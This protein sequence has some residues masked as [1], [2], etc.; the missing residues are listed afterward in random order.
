METILPIEIGVS[1][2]ERLQ[3]PPPVTT[4]L[5]PP[6]INSIQVP[7][8]D[9]PFAR[10]DYPTLEIPRQENFDS[11]VPSKE[12]EVTED[13]K[14]KVRELPETTPPPPIVAAPPLPSPSTVAVPP[15]SPPALPQRE[16][17]S[18]T[19]EVEVA[20]YTLDV[21]TP[22]TVVSAGA[23]AMVGTTA[24][25]VTALAV[26]QAK[27]AVA[28]MLQQAAKNKFKIKLKQVKPLLHFIKEG[29]VVQVMEYTGTGVR[30]LK[31]DV[32]NPEQFLRD[33]VET[34]PLFE[35]ENRIVIDEPI[36]EMFT[37]EGE[38]RFKYFISP[39]KL[40]KKMT[41]RFAI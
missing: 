4:N 15:P 37:K 23:T 38:Q 3:I 26:Q 1:R 7:V 32:D 35:V 41:S 16:V 10:I 31:T 18:A 14:D 36:K 34:N 30:V 12:E 28:P 40:A 19:M 8:I 27:Q 17:P 6:V 29:D 9:V 2:I 24:T 21:P 22:R 11:A 39:K 13:P 5:A 20:G 33:Q 25:L